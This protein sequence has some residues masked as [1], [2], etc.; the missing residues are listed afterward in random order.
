LN[1]IILLDS[2]SFSPFV[3]ISNKNLG[4]S[5]NKNNIISSAHKP[6]SMFVTVLT[7]HL[8]RRQKCLSHSFQSNSKCC[9]FFIWCPNSI[10]LVENF[11]LSLLVC[12]VKVLDQLKMYCYF[13]SQLKFKGSIQVHQTTFDGYNFE[14]LYLLHPLFVY[15]KICWVMFPLKSS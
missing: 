5:T 7:P 12:V 3:H 14:G 4:H 15:N 9:D 8:P 1:F 10:K 11:A 6:S 13:V 2:Q